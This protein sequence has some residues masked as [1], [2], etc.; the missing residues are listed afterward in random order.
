MDIFSGASGKV[1]DAL[2]LWK[3]GSLPAAGDIHVVKT[4][5]NI[6]IFSL[7]WIL[8]IYD[9]GTI[10]GTPSNSLTCTSTL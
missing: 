8:T 1:K 5:A 7:L 3:I 2:R 6:K 9:F 4:A 10:K